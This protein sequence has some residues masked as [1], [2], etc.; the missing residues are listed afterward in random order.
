V[1]KEKFI[2][3]RDDKL[4]LIT[5]ITAGVVAVVGNINI[6]SAL[7]RILSFL[8][9]HYRW[10]AEL[11]TRSPY[12]SM[13]VLFLGALVGLAFVII[14]LHEIGH[15]AAYVLSGA[16]RRHVRFGWRGI[17]PCIYVDQPMQWTVKVIAAATPIGWITVPSAV[18]AAVVRSVAWKEI[19]VFTAIGNLALSVS[20]L[21]LIY[22]YFAVPRKCKIRETQGGEIAEW[23]E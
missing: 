20:D 4:V 17:F 19:L 12:I 14:V 6:N 15:Y 18:A 9:Q 16:P 13:I 7:E 21:Y 22:Q 5:A 23:E 2:R 1:K 11:F 10:A 3:Q 8:I